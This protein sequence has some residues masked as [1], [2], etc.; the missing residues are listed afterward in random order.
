MISVIIPTMWKAP[1][2]H[3]MLPLLNKHSL[4]TEIILVDNNIA[5][6]NVDLI[7]K[8]NKLV[9]LPQEQNIY[10]NP[11]WN[12]GA[13][14][15]KNDRLFF[16]NDDCLVNLDFL[17]DVARYVTD[18][19]GL[20]GFSEMSYCN[21]AI[22]MFTIMKNSGFGDYVTIEESSGTD[23]NSGMPHPAYGSAMLCHKESY[24]EIPEEFKIYYGDLFLY[25]L[26]RIRG[27]TNYVIEDGL[28]LTQM[29]TTVS[30]EHPQIT[31]EKEIFYDVFKR[32]GII[33]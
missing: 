19:N 6:A 12:L 11:A 13:K 25:S 28:V 20:F 21:I 14:V 23:D 15:S 10:V 7:Q 27:K 26:N 17:F 2:I 5:H 4:V 3:H 8:F 24:Q 30:A 31:K 22:E 9:Y 1:H 29:S 33:S 16:L 18:E 32:Y